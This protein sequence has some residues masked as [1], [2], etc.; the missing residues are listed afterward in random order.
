MKKL[1]FLVCMVTSAIS[2][3]AQ[4]NSLPKLRLQEFSTGYNSPLGIENAGDSRLFIVEKEGKIWA[5]D[6]AGN[7]SPFPFLDITSKVLSAGSEQGLLGMAF[8]PAYSVNGYFYIHY[9][10]LDGNSRIARY[11]ISTDPD[12]ADSSSEFGIINITQP[13]ANHNGGQLQFGPDGYLY[14]ALG[15]GGDAADP[16]NNGQHT[17]TLLGKI[18]RLDIRH[19]TNGRNYAIPPT[20]P[21]VGVGGGVKEE[22]WA[23][24]LRNP[25]RFSFDGMNGDLWISDVGQNDWEEINYQPASS[26]GGENYG[27]SCYEGAHFFKWNCDPAA[28]PPV[29][30]VAEFPHQNTANCS[31]SIT[32]GIVYRGGMFP[33][34]FGKYIYTDFCTG[35]F[36]TVYRDHDVWVNRFLT[37]QNPFSYTTFGEDVNNE[38]YVADAAQ[39]IIYHLYDSTAITPLMAA[40]YRITTP[41]DAEELLLF[42]NPN[43]GTFKIQ[44]N[45]FAN[46]EYKVQVY[47]LMGKEVYAEK[48]ISQKGF[49][50]WNITLNSAINGTYLLRIQTPQKIISTKFSVQ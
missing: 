15:D 38:L 31:G 18:L 5:C 33:K 47:D 32:G 22:I 30:P 6:S 50:E 40:Q 36:R 44:F 43:T 46:E 8:D 35:N 34:M 37:K 20:N 19:G 25:W 23:T 45:S 4:T 14:V 28:I 29:F 49:N 9:I 1:T 10:K 7:K 11:K 3:Q 17:N 41:P 16:F 26:D 42:P 39:G 2:I 21:L 48:W 12:S 13:F 24:G 27:W